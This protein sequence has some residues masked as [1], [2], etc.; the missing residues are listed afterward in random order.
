MEA[1][2]AGGSMNEDA[3]RAPQ[4]KTIRRLGSQRHRGRGMREAQVEGAGRRRGPPAA[5]LSLCISL[6]HR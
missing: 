3:L 1:P 5:L 2:D 6:S 4:K